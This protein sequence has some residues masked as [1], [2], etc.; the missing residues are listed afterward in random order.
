VT[1]KPPSSPTALLN[2]TALL[3]PT[4]WFDVTDDAYGAVGDGVVNDTTA[5]QAALTACAAAGGGVVYFPPGTYKLTAALSVSTA[6]QITLRGEA[7]AVN[8]APLA[9]KLYF[10]T[11]LGAGNYAIKPSNASTPAGVLLEN[12]HIVGPTESAALGA[13]P[14]A[15]YG[16][17]AFLYW[18]IRN[19]KVGGFKAGVVFRGDHNIVESSK[20]NNN[21]YNLYWASP[22]VTF[23]DQRIL[24]TDLDGAYFACVGVSTENYIDGCVFSSVHT[25]NAPFCFWKEGAPATTATFISNSTFID[26]SAEGFGNAIMSTQRGAVSDGGNIFGNRFIECSA[27]AKFEAAVRVTGF[28]T[29]S[30]YGFV[31]GDFKNNS[32]EGGSWHTDQAA[33]GTNGWLKVFNFQSTFL[34]YVGTSGS[35]PTNYGTIGATSN[36]FFRDLVTSTLPTV[37]AAASTTLPIHGGVVEVTGG[38]TITEIVAQKPGVR[39]TLVWGAAATF[40]VTDGGNLKLAGNITTHVANGTLTLVSDGTNWCEASRSANG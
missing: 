23:S 36:V 3:V 2:A 21:Y 33:E 4:G 37:A 40:D 29:V 10:S 6:V 11:D 22:G 17:D 38:T 32:F 18:K 28:D 15:M 35:R 25:G 31:C 14:S 5:V 27:G 30:D 19:C 7:V 26:V 9:T 34:D 16:V 8:S 20:I 12:L 24:H 13:S 39:V 1:L